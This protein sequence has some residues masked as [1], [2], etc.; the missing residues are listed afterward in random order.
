MT[1][2]VVLRAEARSEFDEAFDWYERQ[3]PGLGTRFADEI[4][5]ILDQV[6]DAPERYQR[7]DRDVRR[8]VVRHFPYVIVFRIEEVQIVVLAV[9]HGKRHPRTWQSRA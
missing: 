7:V 8:A 5:H 9:F 2:R 4:E 1:R 3:R 6:A